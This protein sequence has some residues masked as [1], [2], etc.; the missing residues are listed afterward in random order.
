MNLVQ[1]IS[2][3]EQDYQQFLAWA[4]A[5]YSKAQ[6]N[7]GTWP[8]DEAQERAQKAFDALLPQGLST[9]DQVTMVKNL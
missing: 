2:M 6:I 8:L 4:I 5:D 3:T 1:L 9:P 7:A